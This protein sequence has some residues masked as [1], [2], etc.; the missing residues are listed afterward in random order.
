[1]QLSL[2]VPISTEPASAT[3]GAAN[4]AAGLPGQPPVDSSPVS[5]DKFLPEGGPT[6]K[7]AAKDEVT[8]AEKTAAILATSF[9]MPATPLPPQMPLATSGETAKTEVP[10][11]IISP[12][13]FASP[14][15]RFPG[16]QTGGGQ[17]ATAT[18]TASVFFASP[19]S[20]AF[21]PAA[22]EPVTGGSAGRQLPVT[23]SG[24]EM[25]VAS[26]VVGTTPMDQRADVSVRPAAAV[27][28]VMPATAGQ[29]LPTG[30]ALAPEKIAAS[31]FLSPENSPAANL[32][33]KKDFLSTGYAAVTMP[34]AGVGISVAQVAAVM[35][36]VPP[37]RPKS[38][39]AA[40]P[41][42]VM[43]VSVET[44]PVL[45]FAADAPAPAATLRE[46]MAAVVSAVTAFER[47][48]STGQKML[49]LQFHVG[50][51]HLALRVELRDGTVH[52]T[53]RTDSA[54][55]RTALAQEWHDVVPPAAG[56]ELRLAEPVFSS[57]PA[58][59][60]ESAFGSLGHGAP[61]QRGQSAPEPVAS[62]LLP[63]FSEPVAAEPASAAAS[64]P[65]STPLLHAFA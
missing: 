32:P 12:V 25:L 4:P 14:S 6:S 33:D 35:P 45:N 19:S 51:E 55:L 11:P 37:I 9:W 42:P 5:F 57:S 46:T 18:A 28:G 63:D 65:A 60:G 64:A 44:R 56:R 30:N 53:F 10:T 13:L 50:D 31:T 17:P 3:A 16:G 23:V 1:M 15:Y 41:V 61:H 7:P 49:D 54:E 22:P 38:A 43:P 59:A 21:I 48:E 8:D 52:T 58:G 29:P 34:A 39:S 36:A 2:P 26:T 40:A 62:V 27:Q 47:G 20:R 24:K